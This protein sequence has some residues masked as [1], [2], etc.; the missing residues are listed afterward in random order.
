[1]HSIFVAVNVAKYISGKT[2]Q[3]SKRNFAGF[4]VRLTAIAV[5][6]SIAVMVISIC[7]INGFRSQISEKV[8]GVWGHVHITHINSQRF[9]EVPFAD[10]VEWIKD[11]KALEQEDIDDEVFGQFSAPVEHIQAFAHFPAIIRAKKE[12]DGLIIKGVDTTFDW[13]RFQMYMDEG[14]TFETYRDSADVRPLMLSRNSA[15][16][17]QLNVGERVVVYFIK[18]GKQIPRRFKITGIYHTGVSEFDQKLAFAPLP[19]VKEVMGWKENQIGGLELYIN[20]L[21]KLED[22]TRY[23]FY[24]IVPNDMYARSIKSKLYPIFQWLELQKVNEYVILILM[25]VIC[26]INM[27]TGILILIFERTHLVGVL[28]SLGYP[29]RTIR[30]VFLYYAA[31][32]L[33]RGLL[34]GN[35]VAFILLLIQYYFQPITLDEESYYLAYAPV[36]F[37]WFRIILVNAG[38]VVLILLCM[39]IPTLLVKKLDPVRALRFR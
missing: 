15:Q 24:E 27:A 9:E 32:I 35:L 5:A 4:I 13:Q 36:K 7:I 34:W 14:E 23:I 3:S 19:H 29:F 21:S 8:F 28:S 1:M 25:L 2:F 31:Y 22:I 11:L 37:D 26:M 6:L 10:T 38:T 20:D 39:L 30:N 17:L 18:D 16:R 12:I 33:S